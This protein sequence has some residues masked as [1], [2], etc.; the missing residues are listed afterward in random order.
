MTP[1]G[2][3]V[4][5]RGETAIAFSGDRWL[6]LQA[7]R[8]RSAHPR[9]SNHRCCDLNSLCASESGW[10][11]HVEVH[12]GGIQVG[13]AANIAIGR[14]DEGGRR[15]DVII[16]TLDIVAIKIDAHVVRAR[17]EIQ[18]DIELADGG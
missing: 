1:V 9:T 12:N 15:E 4:A 6:A 7:I 11:Y 8:N 5:S 16:L 3:T 14:N 10:A 18:L 13:S 17:T 2:V